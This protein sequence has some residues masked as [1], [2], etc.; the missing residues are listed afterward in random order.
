MTLNC[1][2][3]NTKIDK[4]F[5]SLGNLPL[6]NSFVKE[7]DLYKKEEYYPLDVY[8]CPECFLMQIDESED[9]KN[10]FSSI[11]P[12]YSSYSS[13]WL[14]HS[15][16]YVEMMIDKYGYN[17]D[18]FV[19]E[20][21]SNDGYLLQYFKEYNIPHLGVE[22]SS[23]VAQVAID[24]GVN[25]DVSF[26][27]KEYATK[28]RHADLIIGNNVLAHNP[29][30]H[31][32]V[33]GLKIMLKSNGIIT[34]EFPHLLQLIKNNQFDTI[35]HEHFSYF[36]LKS[37]IKLFEYHQLEVFDVD[38][39]S[40]HGGS[41]RVYIKHIDEDI[42]NHDIDKSLKRVKH[43]LDKENTF[44]LYD[45]RIYDIFKDSVYKIKYDFISLLCNLKR[46]K[47]DTTIT[48]YGAAAKGNTLL[49][50]CGTGTEF[51]DFVVDVSPH[52]QG[53]YLP[54]THIPIK[55][56]DELNNF[57]PDYII[58]LPW[59]IKDEILEQLS[60]YDD[61]KIRHFIIAIPKVRII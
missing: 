23:K 47:S 5:L 55:H 19:V 25:T 17:K 29:K 13:S 14:D 32:F 3:C 36:S 49:N 16:K 45:L 50:F 6:S 60:Y 27:N 51:I 54:G 26:F 24:K 39:L 37:I 34:L 43:V 59:N 21:A 42:T 38:E 31:D 40:T 61:Y 1:R 46:Y 2:I 18:S 10:I 20:I 44:N 33:Q 48:C 56:P 12:Y 11:Y 58:I 7:E 41:L 57:K 4:P 22:P 15:K 28:N 9:I 53:M 35:Y 30:L 52:K 8:I